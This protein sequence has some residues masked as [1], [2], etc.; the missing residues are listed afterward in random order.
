MTTRDPYTGLT[1]VELY[2]RLTRAHDATT[3]DELLDAILDHPDYAPHEAT[4]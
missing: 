2:R 3:R 1:L 4:R